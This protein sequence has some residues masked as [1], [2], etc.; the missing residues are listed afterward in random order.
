M[1]LYFKKLIIQ[2]HEDFLFSLLFFII[3][4]NSVRIFHVFGSQKKTE[5][6]R[7][8]LIL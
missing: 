3:Y 4:D 2:W 7:N 8:A 5:R 6:I 1:D